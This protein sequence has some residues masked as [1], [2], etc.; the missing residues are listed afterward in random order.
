M[1]DLYRPDELEAE[2]DR[3]RAELARLQGVERAAIEGAIAAAQGKP[4]SAASE[5]GYKAR[6][7]CGDA[8]ERGWQYTAQHWGSLD[9]FESDGI[10]ELAAKDDLL[11]KANVEIDRLN[12]KLADKHGELADAN[13]RIEELGTCV[14]ALFRLEELRDAWSRA[15]IAERDNLG[16]TRSNRNVD[17]EIALRKVLYGPVGS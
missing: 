8:W 10:P 17:V 2:I 14:N 5:S 13:K 11:R 16:G 12:I 9:C 6:S 7:A 15:V 3:L 4:I 1:A